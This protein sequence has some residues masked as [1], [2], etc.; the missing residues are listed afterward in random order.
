MFLSFVVSCTVRTTIHE[1]RRKTEWKRYIRQL[2]RHMFLF[3]FFIYL[4]VVDQ[5]KLCI[6]LL[7]SNGFLGRAQTHE[8][9]AWAFEFISTLEF[10]H[11]FFLLQI[12][13]VME[14]N[15]IFSVFRDCSHRKRAEAR[16]CIYVSEHECVCEMPIHARLFVCVCACMAN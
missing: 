8:M 2:I 3:F 12:F 1:R 6:E 11:F 7:K 15:F 16:A 14:L 4:M 10:G 9:Y 5:K 13:V